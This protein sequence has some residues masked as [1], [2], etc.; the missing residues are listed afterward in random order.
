MALINYS[1][2]IIESAI[3]TIAKG[4]KEVYPSH[5]VYFYGATWFHEGVLYSLNLLVFQEFVI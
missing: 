4:F 1:P 3:A 2:I 5:Q